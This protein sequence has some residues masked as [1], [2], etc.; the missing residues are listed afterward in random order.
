MQKKNEVLA[1][2]SSFSLRCATDREYGDKNL[3]LY[4]GSAEVALREA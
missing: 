2:K 3:S 4:K 1:L